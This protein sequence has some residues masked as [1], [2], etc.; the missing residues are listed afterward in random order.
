MNKNSFK[1]YG[2]YHFWPCSYGQYG[3]PVY[4]DLSP[5]LEGCRS[6]SGAYYAVADDSFP[7]LE[8]A[9]RLALDAGISIVEVKYADLRP[10]GYSPSYSWVIYGAQDIV[11]LA[12]SSPRTDVATVR[13]LIPG[14]TTVTLV[15]DND[16]II[17]T[18]QCV[19]RVIDEYQDGDVN[20]DG[21]VNATDAL[22]ALQHSVGLIA[23]DGDSLSLADVDENG[24]IDAADCFKILQI[25]VGLLP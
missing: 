13:G 7:A 1:K 14:T 3:F 16:G 8:I 25:S 6:E 10:G 5:E 18:D 22:L 4:A 24:T 19:I 12:Y 11:D 15:V 17:F 20:C 21:K 9:D 23:L 2:A